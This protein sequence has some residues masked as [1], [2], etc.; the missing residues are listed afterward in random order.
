M[1]SLPRVALTVSTMRMARTAPESQIFSSRPDTEAG[2]RR[3][4][5]VAPLPDSWTSVKYL[6]I[7]ALMEGTV[8]SLNKVMK[9]WYNYFLLHL[10]CLSVPMSPFRVLGEKN[11][12]VGYPII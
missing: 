3:G 7:S 4:Q 10:F 1:T 9:F 12:I 2:T 6:T 11:L 8:F 5:E